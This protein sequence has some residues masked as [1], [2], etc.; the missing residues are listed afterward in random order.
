MKFFITYDANT[1][2]GLAEITY[3]MTRSFENYFTDRFYDDSGIEM[4]IILMCRDPRLN[5]KQRVRFVKKENCLY[6]DIM[7]DL[8]VM[9]RSDPETRKRIVAEKIMTEVPQ[10]VMKRRFKDFDLP[11]FTKDLREWFENH[12]W[13][14]PGFPELIH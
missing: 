10:I 14:D 9:S 13:I 8:H 11:R 1:E 6:M 7:L 5:F 3:G 2:S 12:N 4:A